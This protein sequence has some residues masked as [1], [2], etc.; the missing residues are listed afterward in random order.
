MWSSFLDIVFPRQC[1]GCGAWG[2]YICP[3]C[4]K[5]INY[6]EKQICS[7][8]KSNSADGL[9]H[10]LCRDKDGLDGLFVLAH[11]NG[12]AKT[13]IQEI[14]Y[15]GIFAAS[16]EVAALI[17]K[18]YHN[19]FTFDYFVPVPLSKNRERLR[20]FNQAEKLSKQLKIKQSIN[21]LT[22][23]KDTKPQFDLSQK[24]R[25]T[26]VKNVFTLSSNL[27]SSSLYGISFCLVDDV[28]T[29]G[30]TLSECAKVLKSHGAKSVYAITIASGS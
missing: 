13:I 4:T 15:Q 28:T 16:D 18:H 17:R 8:C 21:L 5:T 25:E 10:P 26:N 11:Y 9:A 14:K 30:S 6:F 23:P 29:T 24:D 22:R 3:R 20:G 2:K 7:F 1:F 19:K 27:V 12:L